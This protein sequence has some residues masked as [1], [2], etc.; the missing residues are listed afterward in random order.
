MHRSQAIPAADMN[1]GTA[2]D[3]TT[4]E[5]ISI[6]L[7]LRP[8]AGTPPLAKGSGHGRRSVLLR[9]KLTAQYWQQRNHATSP[10][11]A[12]GQPKMGA[13]A[14]WLARSLA[15]R[16]PGALA[17]WLDWVACLLALR[18]WLARYLLAFCWPLAACFPSDCPTASHLHAA[19]DML[20]SILRGLVGGTAGL[21]KMPPTTLPAI[22]QG[23]T[24]GAY[25]TVPSAELDACA[26]TATPPSET[27]PWS[28]RTARDCTLW[29]TMAPVAWRVEGRSSSS[30]ASL[31]S[32]LAGERSLL[33]FAACRATV[34]A[35]S[36]RVI[37]GLSDARREHKS[38]DIDR[39]LVPDV[40]AAVQHLASPAGGGHKPL[41]VAHDWGAGVDAG[42][43]VSYLGGSV[44]HTA[45]YVSLS[46]PPS[47]AFNRGMKRLSQLWASAYMIF[48]QAHSCQ[49]CCSAHATHG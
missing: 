19:M 28:H 43:D 2:T 31:S 21:I 23:K 11:G 24:P 44:Q 34:L 42:Q 49:S 27:S 29:K 26:T 6:P 14:A 3:K 13:P 45:G 40:R 38:H 4:T 9:Q 48:F 7:R 39:C 20:A 46:N 41:L 35:L 33:H 15:Q 25:T 8:A 47:E 1:A 17:R 36:M 32:G 22:W 16:M 5:T 37:A 10:P 12:A 18:C 30:T